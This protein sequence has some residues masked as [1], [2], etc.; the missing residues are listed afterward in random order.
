MVRLSWTG[1]ELAMLVALLCLVTT[2]SIQAQI[3]AQSSVP[4]SVQI[5]APP[6]DASS[7]E[8][9]QKG[10]EL[11]GQ[12]FYRE[13]RE[14]YSEAIKRSRENPA[15]LYNKTGLVQLQEE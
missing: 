8:L 7:S 13:A 2:T 1:S 11:R 12:K 5:P 6:A 3:S 4:S 14:Y 9:E 15:V 10:D